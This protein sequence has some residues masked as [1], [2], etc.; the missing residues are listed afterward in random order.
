MDPN[1]NP[2]PNPNPSPSAYQ[3]FVT[4]RSVAEKKLVAMADRY[5]NTLHTTDLKEHSRPSAVS[6]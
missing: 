3:G 4:G 1:L 2:N 6:C 5:T